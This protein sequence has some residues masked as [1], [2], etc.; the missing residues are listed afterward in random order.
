MAIP[1]I[2][3]FAATIFKIILKTIF[4][5]GEGKY[6]VTASPIQNHLFWMRQLQATHPRLVSSKL[7]IVMIDLNQ[8]M[9][10][11]LASDYDMRDLFQ[12][13]GCKLL[14]STPFFFSSW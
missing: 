10:Y 13:P 8:S 7:R 2:Y 4:N 6:V 9:I 11:R 1:K 12:I 5:R 14:N 3:H